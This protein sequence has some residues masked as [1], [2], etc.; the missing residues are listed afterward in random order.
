MNEEYTLE[1]YRNDGTHEKQID[2]FDTYEQADA[3]AE[4]NPAD[5]NHYYSI[6]CIEYDKDGNEINSYPVY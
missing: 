2:V 5:E 4:S 1:L 3:F 6:F